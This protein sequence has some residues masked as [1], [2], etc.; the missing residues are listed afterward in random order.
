MKIPIFLLFNWTRI[1]SI[2]S[3]LSVSHERFETVI[4]RK[5]HM[6]SD[7]RSNFVNISIWINWISHT[8]LDDTHFALPVQTSLHSLSLSSFHAQISHG[9][10]SIITSLPKRRFNWMK[11]NKYFSMSCTFPIIQFVFK[12]KDSPLNRNVQFYGRKD[13]ILR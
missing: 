10:A 7:L 2:R 6:H 3:I 12:H 13:I 11:C 4:A 1:A 9:F 8:V 5:T